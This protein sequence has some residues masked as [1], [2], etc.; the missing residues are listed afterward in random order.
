[1]IV[2]WPLLVIA[3]A[4]WLVIISPFT[5]YWVI[6]KLEKLSMI[7]CNKILW[8]FVLNTCLQSRWKI[9]CLWLKVA[10]RVRIRNDVIWSRV[11]KILNIVFVI[12]RCHKGLFFCWE[13]VKSVKKHHS[14]I[15]VF[16]IS[17]WA[18]PFFFQQH[19]QDL[20][21]HEVEYCTLTYQFRGE[22]L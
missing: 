11:I 18:P 7:V 5:Y 12:V 3:S 4:S 8:A 6:D 14:K 10:W 1:L 20:P 21:K 17:W 15:I 22:V 9:L 19:R 13:H 2:A 16:W